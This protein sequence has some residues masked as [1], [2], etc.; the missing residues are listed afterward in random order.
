MSPLLFCSIK[1][2]ILASA[3]P[4]RREMLASLGMD[5]QVACADIDESVLAGEGAGEHVVRLARA[6]ALAVAEAE[7]SSW[8][9][10][11]DTVVVVD[12]E[13][14]G[15]PAGEEEARA[16]LAR[17]SGRSH[18]VWTGFALGRLGAVSARAVM[19]EVTFIELSPSLVAAYVK[20]GEPLDKAGAYGIQGLASSFV[21]RIS[22]SYSNVV[23]LPLAE[24][25][26]ELL[27]AG[28][29]VPAS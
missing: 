26:S 3:S 29:I 9:I 16:M 27:A 23:G 14:L 5:F 1:P 8:V 17:L 11:A 15:K 2:L 7:L 28:I 18:Q 25:V 13:I 20:S 19:S 4:R 21:S 6:K 12:D 10:A 22:G 24:V